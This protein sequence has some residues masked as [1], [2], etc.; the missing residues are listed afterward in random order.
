MQSYTTLFLLSATSLL[1]LAV[2]SPLKSDME[3]V[4]VIV[5]A[6]MGDDHKEEALDQAA[7]YYFSEANQQQIPVSEAIYEAMTKENAAEQADETGTYIM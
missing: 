6:F 3:M 5:Q 4:K 2:A 1:A 7:P